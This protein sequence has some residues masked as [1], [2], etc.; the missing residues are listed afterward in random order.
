MSILVGRQ[1]P[2]FTLPAVLGNGEIVD[3]FNLYER[4]KGRHALLFFT[5]LTL[6]LSVL[7]N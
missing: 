6:H 3:K 2:D 4:I 1:A 5:R 7:Q